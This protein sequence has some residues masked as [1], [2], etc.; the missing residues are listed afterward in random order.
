MENSNSLDQLINEYSASLLKTYEKRNPFLQTEDTSIVQDVEPAKDVQAETVS[1]P[2]ESE[3]GFSREEA[4]TDALTDTATFFATVRTGGEA[5]PVSG[6][7]II[8]RKGDS[9][10]SF[11]VTDENGE[12]LKVT[13]PAYPKED[14]LSAETVKVVNYFADVFREGFQ[15]KRNLP[16]TAVGGAE[17][18]LNVELTPNEERME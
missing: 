1:E 4:T 17:I 8:I 18:V 2:Q 10:M 3:S 12:T 14:S 5:Y 15:E 13:L 11:L 6:A 16:V 7:K 9:I